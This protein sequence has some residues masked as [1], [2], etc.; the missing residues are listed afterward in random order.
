MFHCCYWKGNFPIPHSC[1]W[2]T[3]CFS[4]AL[5]GLLLSFV[6]VCPSWCTAVFPAFVSRSLSRGYYDL[7]SRRLMAVPPFPLSTSLLL[8]TCMIL[9][10]IQQT[11]FIFFFFCELGD[12]ARWSLSILCGLLSILI[13]RY[14][15]I[16]SYVPDCYSSRMT[17]S[18]VNSSWWATHQLACHRK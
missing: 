1:L 16:F 14:L 10:W 11:Q 18:A 2:M 9:F 6:T 15:C 4:S 8:F 5:Y 7:L 12:D 17:T 3:V 13:V